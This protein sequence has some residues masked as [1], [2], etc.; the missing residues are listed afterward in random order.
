YDRDQEAL[1]LWDGEQD[2]AFVGLCA[3]DPHSRLDLR[4]N[5]MAWQV[6]LEV[7]LPQAPQD[8][9]EAIIA[10]LLHG[11]F[12]CAAGVFGKHPSLEFAGELATGQR[13]GGGDT[14]HMNDTEALVVK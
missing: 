8:R 14:V 13:V 11:R 12:H 1:E 5:M 10:A 2:P 4:L 6:V 9:S 3:P 7:P